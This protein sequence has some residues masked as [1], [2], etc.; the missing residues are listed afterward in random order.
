MKLTR[1]PAIARQVAVVDGIQGCGKTLFSSI[2]SSLERMEIEKYNYPL[3]LS[4]QSAWL[5]LCDEQAAVMMAR[6]LTDID[7]YQGMM[8]RETNFRYSDLSG[9]FHT[10]R[11]WRYFARL[12][13][14]GDGA[15]IPQ[16][17]RERPILNLVTHNLLVTGTPIFK[18]LG[19]RLSF[20]EVVR[21]PLYM[22][23]QIRLFMPRAGKDPRIFSFWLEH[24]G[25]AIP[26]FAK[27]WEALWAASNDMDRSIHMMDRLLAAARATQAS[28]APEHKA[29]VLIVPFEPFVL[30][31]EPWMTRLTVLLGTEAGATARRELARQKVPRARIADGIDLKVYR[32]NGWRPSEKGDEAAELKSRW[33]YASAEATPPG[34]E[35]LRRLCRDYESRYLKATAAE[36][37]EVPA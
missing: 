28:L 31:P 19:S 30:D 22:L 27:G 8:S 29:R 24:E 15:V 5:G 2:V 36:A 14:P 17:E 13:Q 20:I 4:C 3:E 33:D 10:P 34:L 16:I 21:H 18:A 11:A 1:E 32:D 35:V 9:V 25:R 37:V 26:W 6:M 7:L 12:F 23:K